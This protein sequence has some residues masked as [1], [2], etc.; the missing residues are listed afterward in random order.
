VN[1][2]WKEGDIF[3]CPKYKV[4]GIV[5]N[6]GSAVASQWGWP[7]TRYHLPKVPHDAK[8]VDCIPTTDDRHLVWMELF[9]HQS[10]IARTCKNTA[11]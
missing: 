6:D 1:N 7:A 4:I 8:K 2:R 3:E 5:M 10:Q 9:I 11:L